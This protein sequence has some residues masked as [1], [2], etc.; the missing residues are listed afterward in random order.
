[1][2]E[3][4]CQG[5][6]RLATGV[7]PE[8]VPVLEDLDEELLDDVVG[9]R[10]RL[11]AGVLAVQEATGVVHQAI[12]GELQQSLPGLGV[13]RHGPLQ[14]PLED[15]GRFVVHGLRPFAAADKSRALS[16]FESDGVQ[17]EI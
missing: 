5:P 6:H 7:Y 8:A 3:E 11:E 10:E 4:L 12:A 2:A 9:L 13:A 17:Q 16:L 15:G 14:L 1:V